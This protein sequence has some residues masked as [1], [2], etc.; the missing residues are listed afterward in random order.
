MLAPGC[1]LHC[2][3]ATHAA[4]LPRSPQG[5]DLTD[6]ELMEYISESTTMSKAME[7]YGDRKSC[8]ITTAKRLSLFLGEWG[9]GQAVACRTGSTLPWT[10]CRNDAV[11]EQHSSSSSSIYAGS[12]LAL[13]LHWCD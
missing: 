6:S 12:I 9:G 13:L 1:L 7:E 3:L 2:V 5:I 11:Q 10:T 4:L 8:A